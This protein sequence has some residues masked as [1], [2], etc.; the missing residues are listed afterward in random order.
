[1]ASWWVEYSLEAAN[2]FADNGESVT[3]LFF[4]IEAMAENEGWPQRGYVDVGEGRY[5]FYGEGY[6]VTFRRD[7]ANQLVKIET[8]QSVG[9]ANR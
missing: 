4:A 9:Q 7:A 1:M 5:L 8:I 6:L 3:S 2:Y